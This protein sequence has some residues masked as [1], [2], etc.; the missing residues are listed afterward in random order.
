[1]PLCCIVLLSNICEDLQLILAACYVT[2][3]VVALLRLLLYPRL[4]EPDMLSH[5]HTSTQQY[6]LIYMRKQKVRNPTYNSTQSRS[7]SPIP[8]LSL[9]LNLHPNANLN[10]S[11]N[12]SQLLTLLTLTVPLKRQNSPLFDEQAHKTTPTTPYL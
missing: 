12:L 7:E 10:A 3:T 4:S 6:M 8:T 9:K 11:P 2:A 5:P 1:M